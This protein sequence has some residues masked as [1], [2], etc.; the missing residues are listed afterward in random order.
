M[1]RYQIRPLAGSEEGTEGPL[2]TREKLYAAER[3]ALNVAREHG[4]AGVFAGLRYQEQVRVAL[5]DTAADL[6][7][8]LEQGPILVVTPVEV[9]MLRR[10]VR[11]GWAD[12]IRNG[13]CITTD[14][15]L[16]QQSEKTLGRHT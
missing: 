9:A 10:F 6:L 4:M 16:V 3:L 11:L 7:C 8:R 1:E 2:W 5:S 14:G 15:I 12:V 13:W